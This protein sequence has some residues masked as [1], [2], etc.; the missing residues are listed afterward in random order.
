[1]TTNRTAQET[2]KSPNN[3]CQKDLT[4]TEW[5]LIPRHGR[6]ACTLHNQYHMD[7]VLII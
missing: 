5:P 7:K 1:M 6:M 4:D 3:R 2:H